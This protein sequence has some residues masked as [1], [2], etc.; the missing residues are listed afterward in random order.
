MKTSY[1]IAVR[2]LTLIS[3]ASI[4]CW[5]ILLGAQLSPK[6]SQVEF[7]QV[8]TKLQ[9]LTGA[10]NPTRVIESRTQSAGGLLETRI[11]EA[12]SING[13]YAPISMSER[14]TVQLDASTVRVVQRVFAI[15]PDGKRTLSQVTEEKRTKTPDGENV[16]RTTSNSDVNGHLQVVQRDVE[17]THT[18][19]SVEETT[20]T[21]LRLSANGLTPA[22]TR[23]LTTERQGAGATHSITT[24]SVADANGGFLPVQVTEV[25]QTEANGVQKREERIS[26]DTGN[27]LTLVEQNV[28]TETQT[29]SQSRG[30]VEVFRR[31]LPGVAPDSQLHLAGQRETVRTTL[32]DGTTRA[33]QTEK[34]VLPGSTTHEL[35]FENRT[36]ETSRP[37]AAGQSQ[38]ERK[39]EAWDGNQGLRPVWIIDSKGTRRSE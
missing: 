26:R 18:T 7:S 20:G 1:F 12:R 22:F 33:E 2:G 39:V 29:G 35:R 24:L 36:I 8:T 34:Q 13:G 16:E 37:S 9:D 25:A 4:V 5:P 15:N 6:P 28:K 21:T 10:T 30:K 31:E 32:P 3:V 19:G 17:S 14:E 38:T 11:T 23:R 27:G